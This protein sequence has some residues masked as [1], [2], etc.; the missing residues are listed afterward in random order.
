MK[1][2]L[3]ALD[4]AKYPVPEDWPWEDAHEFF[5]NPEVV[6]PEVS[7]THTQ[8]YARTHVELMQ[9]AQLAALQIDAVGSSCVYLQA[10]AYKCSKL[11]CL[12]LCVCVCVCVCPYTGDPASQVVRP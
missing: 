9:R 11:P 1:T 6:K 8:T 2:L 12:C 10:V 7:D 4:P 3:S 5:K